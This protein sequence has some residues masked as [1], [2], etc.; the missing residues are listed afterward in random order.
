MIGNNP[1]SIEFRKLLSEGKIRHEDISF[2]EEEYTKISLTRCLVNGNKLLDENNLKLDSMK[3]KPIKGRPD[4]FEKTKYLFQFPKDTETVKFKNIEPFFLEFP[5]KKDHIY[6]CKLDP[7]INQ[8][9]ESSKYISCTKYTYDITDLLIKEILVIKG[10]VIGAAFEFSPINRKIKFPIN[11][12]SKK[13]FYNLL[14][15]FNYL[16]AFD[17]SHNV[18]TTLHLYVEETEPPD[19]KLSYYK[20]ND[21]F[22]LYLP[23]VGTFIRGNIF[24]CMLSYKGEIIFFSGK[25]DENIIKSS[26]LNKLFFRETIPL[27]LPVEEASKYISDNFVH[28]VDSIRLFMGES[29]EIFKK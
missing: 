16:L 11:K 28:I 5:S 23:I 7:P 20:C 18:K 8:V 4:H 10:N 6:Q 17:R 19:I 24:E 22:D 15:S 12:S 27:S 2:I 29:I 21:I 13:E 26:A 25:V 9:V 3:I 1:K 14:D